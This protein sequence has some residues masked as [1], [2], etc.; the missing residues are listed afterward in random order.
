VPRR[1][2]EFSIPPPDWLD[3]PL[4]AVLHDLQQ[5]HPVPIRYG[6]SEDADGR[7]LWIKELRGYGG[8]GFLIPS[9]TTGPELTAWLAEQL[10]EQFF[11]ESAAAWGE[12]RPACPGHPHPASACGD[13]H[14][15]WWCCPVDSRRI[16]A[17]GAYTSE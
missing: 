7:W 16:A 2:P 6:C 4:R 8:S 5:P 9:E 12:A 17:I 14:E 13:E 15:A 3:E 1:E 10:Q 11:A